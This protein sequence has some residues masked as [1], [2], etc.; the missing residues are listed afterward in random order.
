MKI[1][2]PLRPLPQGGGN[3][4]I[5]LLQEYLNSSHI[6]WTEDLNRSYDILFVNSWQVPY[7]LI[8]R[9]KQRMKTLKVIHRVDGSAQDYGRY[10]NADAKQARVNLLADATVFQSYYGKNSTRNRFKVIQKDGPVIYN[11]VDIEMFNPEGERLSLPGTIRV[12]SA[13]WS[14]NRKKG[15]WQIPQLAS[16]NPEITFVLCGQYP[17]IPCLPNI[18]HYQYL[19]YADLAKVMRSCDLYLDLSEN[20]CCPNTVLQAMASGLP[21]LHKLSGG[22]PELTAETGIILDQDAGNFRQA[23]EQAMDCQRLLSEKVRKRVVEKNAPSLIFSQYLKVMEEAERQPLPQ[24]LDIIK[25]A[26]NGYPVLPGFLA[27]LPLSWIKNYVI[28]DEKTR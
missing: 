23:L 14:M 5:Y 20:D 26:L 6:P 9:A 21:V 17:E 8:K 27:K 24:T 2:I 18:Y 22:I 7:K 16:K 12:C 19:P 13:A 15:T 4:F 28:K 11:P 25:S 10:D 3:Y 1:C